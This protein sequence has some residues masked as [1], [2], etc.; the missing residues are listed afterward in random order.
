[1]IRHPA[2]AYRTDDPVLTAEYHLHTLQVADL[3]AQIVQYAE[4]VGGTDARVWGGEG[5]GLF[6]VGIL[7]QFVGQPAPRG[8]CEYEGWW[9]PD[10]QTD[11]GRGHARHF[12]RLGLD[13]CELKGM[14]SELH[15]GD[16]AVQRRLEI[17]GGYLWATWSHDT[18]WAESDMDEPWERVPL[19]EYHSFVE[20]AIEA[21][22][23]R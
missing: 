16:V 22:Q 2:T 11:E 6:V 1:M 21:G 3:H 7:P 10:E 15:R 9:V 17:F 19:S 13:R 20:L 4:D 5:E 23:I 12:E 14:P 8:M 18:A